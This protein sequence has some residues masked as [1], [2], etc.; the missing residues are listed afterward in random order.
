M[1]GV[2]L[3]GWYAARFDP[4]KDP[5]SF[6]VAI[7]IGLL[8]GIILVYVFPYVFSLSNRFRPSEVLIRTKNIMRLQGNSASEISLKAISSYYWLSH[9]DFI[10]LAVLTNRKQPTVFGVPDAETKQKIE[11]VLGSLGIPQSNAEPDDRT[12]AADYTGGR[13]E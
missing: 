11:N 5:V 3:L 8:S 4:A 10:I 12:D 9:E 2:V 6:P 7:G 1:I 13:D